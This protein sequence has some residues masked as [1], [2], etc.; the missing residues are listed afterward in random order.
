LARQRFGLRQPSAAFASPV[1]RG[2]SGRGL[3]QS[4]TSRNFSG[5][6]EK[7]GHSF[8]ETRSSGKIEIQKKVKK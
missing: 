1:L 3:P 4:K 6:M 7:H 8:I 2:K 5:A